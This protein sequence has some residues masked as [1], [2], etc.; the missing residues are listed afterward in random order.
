MSESY[1]CFD[2]KS[3]FTFICKDDVIYTHYGMEI[4]IR[5]EKCFS[6]KNESKNELKTRD[7]L[8]GFVK[9]EIDL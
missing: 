8:A 2:E 9:V 3:D 7:L 1:V 6:G 5:S 4:D